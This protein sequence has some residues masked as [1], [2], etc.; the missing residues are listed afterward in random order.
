MRRSGA[1]LPI[2]NRARSRYFRQMIDIH[3][4]IL[5]GLDDGAHNLEDAL[6]MMLRLAVEHGTTE[7]VATPHANPQFRFDGA[8]VERCL[9]E[10][11][12]AAGAGPRIHYGCEM[13]LTPEN[14]EEMLRTPSRYTIGHRGYV[15]V[16][17]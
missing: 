16:E 13:H 7:L 5:P 8:K 3:S 4:H 14:I 12:E 17:F 6:A 9:A 10:L 11:R 2:E 1:I 15:L